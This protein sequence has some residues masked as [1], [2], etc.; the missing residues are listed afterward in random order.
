MSDAIE[1]LRR[2][3]GNILQQVES[4]PGMTLHDLFF[5]GAEASRL[6]QYRQ[7]NT[8]LADV[9]Q[10]CRNPEPGHVDAGKS[11]FDC[12]PDGNAGDQQAMLERAFVVATHLVEK[13]CES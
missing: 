4:G 1:D 11:D 8:G 7:R 12:K 13:T 10:R 9:V 3:A 5:S 6:V 2:H